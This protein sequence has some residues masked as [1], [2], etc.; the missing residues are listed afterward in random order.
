LDAFSRENYQQYMGMLCQELSRDGLSHIRKSAG[1]IMKN[2]LTAKD[3][4]KQ[5][6]L[7]RR[8]LLVDLSGREQIK[9]M[10]L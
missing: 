5:E 1:L 10:V 8:W 9:Q 6:E 7:S 3:F 2:S 4:E